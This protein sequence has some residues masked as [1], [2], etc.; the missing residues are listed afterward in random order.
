MWSRTLQE[1][2]ADDKWPSEW[3]LT[4]P[5]G[6]RVKCRIVSRSYLNKLNARA[7]GGLAALAL[8]F[9]FGEKVLEGHLPDKTGRIYFSREMT[10]AQ[11]AHVYFHET[12]HMFIEW[13]GDMH[14]KL[15]ELA[16]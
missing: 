13:T 6:Y 11:F 7:G 2:V 4:F 9:P 8:S 14:D 10:L 15:L 12:H 5:A 16:K 3:V 1:L